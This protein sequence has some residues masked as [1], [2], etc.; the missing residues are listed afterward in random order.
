MVTTALM[1]TSG[2]TLETATKR[3]ET[4]EWFSLLFK[5]QESKRHLHTTTK[6][7]G[8]ESWLSYMF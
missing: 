6:M 8:N 4:E 5:P 7:D 2:A 1:S 3:Q